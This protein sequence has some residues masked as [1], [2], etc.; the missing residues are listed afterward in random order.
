M[1]LGLCVRVCECVGE[2]G[3]ACLHV[4]VH[5][6]VRLGVCVCAC[7]CE[8]EKQN[9]TSCLFLSQ[10]ITINLRANVFKE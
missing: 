5:V 4:C 1:H 9:Y 6:V 3:C 2:H 8:R 10:A 7:A